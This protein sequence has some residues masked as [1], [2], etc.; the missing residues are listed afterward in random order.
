MAHIGTLYIP[1]ELLERTAYEID[2]KDL[3]ALRCV[4]SDFCA[5]LDSILFSKI[6]IDLKNHSPSHALHKL[7]LL[8]NE[9]GRISPSI[10]ALEFRSPEIKYD[11]SE[12]DDWM[13]SLVLANK[14]YDEQLLI[15][16]QARVCF[17][18]AFRLMKNLHTVQ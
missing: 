15:Q 5:I 8:A 11:R 1:T 10:R 4:N 9:H 7:Q 12:S 6:K 17:L 16:R 13:P 3:K 18:K 2:G 14:R